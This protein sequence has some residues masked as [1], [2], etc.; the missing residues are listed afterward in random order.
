MT[1]R[2]FWLLPG[3]VLAACTGLR[4]VRPDVFRSP[5]PGEDQL[6]RRIEALGIRTVVCLRL[7][8]EGN[9]ASARAAEGASIAFWHVPMSATRLPSAA[10]LLEL[11]R[12]AASARRPLL[13]HCLAGIDRTGLA[14][15]IL[16]LHDTGDLAQARRELALVPHGHLGVFGTESMREVLDRYE[17]HAG[18]LTFPEWVREV[19]ATEV[20]PSPH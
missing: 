20:A 13:L 8:G 14:S 15:A 6:A 12:V 7:A 5:Q 2:A 10:T 1:A 18:R 4:T 16:V 9:A 19:Y 3:L 11:W 17:G